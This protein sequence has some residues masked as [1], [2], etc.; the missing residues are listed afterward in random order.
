M[1]EAI[2]HTARPQPAE[3]VTPNSPVAAAARVQP[4]RLIAGGQI[5]RRP[6]AFTFDGR[7]YQGF[8]GDT[9]ASALLANGVRLVG[10]SFKYH[11]PRGIVSAGP[12]EPNALVELREGAR[13]EPNTRATTAELFDGLVARSQNRWP[14]LRFDIMAVNSLVAPILAAGF[15]Y[16]TFMW[17]S[18][19][20][21]KVYEPAIRRAAGLGRAA[22]APDPDRYEK[23][24][25]FC[26]VLI[27]GGGPAGL[28]AALAA[29][30]SGARVILI[31]QDFALGGRLLAEQRSIGG[32]SG[33][34]FVTSVEA[35]LASL[36]EVRIL[37]RTTAFGVYDGGTYAAVE[38]VNDHVPSPPPH[39]PRQRLWRIVARR[40]ILAA[41]AIERPIVFSDNDRPGVMLAGAVRSYVNRFAVKPGAR[42]VLFGNNDDA[43]RTAR[44][45]AEAGVEI[46]AVVDPRP[47]ALLGLE[48]LSREG[49]TRL[50]EGVVTRAVGGTALAAAEIRDA[51]GAIASLPCDLVAVSGGWQPTVHLTSHLGGRPE[52]DPALA[53]FVPGTLPPGMAVIGA[54]KGD[55]A[56]AACLA[57]GIR[58]GAD[59]AAAC[60]FQPRSVTIPPADAESTAVTPLWR[61]KAAGSKPGKAFVDLQNDVTTGDVALAHREGFRAVEHLK[62]YTTLGMATDQ[63]KTSNVNGLALMAELTGQSVASTGTTRFRP[64]YTPVAVGALAGHHKAGSLKP[65]RLTPAHDWAAQRGAVFIETGL[66]LRASHFPQPGDR[67]WR[68][69][70][71]REVRA[72]RE[73]VGLCDVSTLGKIEVVGR[74]AA[75]FLDRVYANLMSSLPVGRARY[76]LML[77][78]DGFV[79]DDGTLARLEPERYVLTTTTA[80]AVKVM[81]HMEFC[82]QVLWPEL[83]VTMASVTEHWAQFA[84][85]GPRSREVLAAVLTEVDLSNAAFPFMA[86]GQVRLKDGPRGRLFRISFSGELAYE[87]AVPARF[88]P[89]VARALMAAGEAFGMAPYGLEALNVLRIEKGHAA[90]G[91][92]NGQTTA[93]DLGLGRMVSAKK[94]FVGAVMAARPALVDADRPTLVGFRPVNPA[95]P[96]GAGA[97]LLRPGAENKARNDEGYVTSAAWSPT[98]GWIALGL[99]RRGP[100]RLGERVR[101]FDPVRGRDTLVEVCSPVFYD[102]EGLRLRG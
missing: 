49:G 94:D 1:S 39:E 101:A 55:F 52:W 35:E 36:P 31:E 64:P 79:M 11:R 44:D 100:Q 80:N 9:L 16:K 29:G 95:E 57:D 74:D 77:R 70:C 32:Q 98:F 8:A 14:S 23:A 28:M 92:L 12:E 50:I 20:W 63:G 43:L 90:G 86:A 68:D 17:P 27:I 33:P 18:A 69:A 53:A 62:R 56:L 54:A 34:A 40:T 48:A 13:R 26:D 89:S 84:V 38:R 73:R 41:G 91:E 93:Q 75:A 6:L 71:N 59:A 78:E 2:P 45:L 76:G 96:I 5:E 37:R 58:A 7:Q 3:R 22:E 10:R 65:T 51:K 60:G 87:L 82:A 85:A 19:F 47:D 97:H 99:L 30:R 4:Y 88:G 81:G 102:P 15:Y 67:D 21:E 61:V 66:W 24:N 42:A 83:D 46:A 25:A 72:V